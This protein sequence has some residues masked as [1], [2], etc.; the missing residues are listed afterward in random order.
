MD[1]TVKDLGI[2]FPNGGEIPEVLGSGLRYGVAR[3]GQDGRK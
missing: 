3:W 1:L 2:F